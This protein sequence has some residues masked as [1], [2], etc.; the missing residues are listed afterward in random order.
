MDTLMLLMTKF[1]TQTPY[2]YYELA[3]FSLVVE[4]R[5][6]TAAARLAGYPQSA[7]TLQIQG[8]EKA[9]GVHL[10]KRTTRSISLTGAGEYLFR[11]ASRLVGDVES[12]LRFLQ[13]EFANA[14]KEIRVAVS[15]SIGLAYL[16]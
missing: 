9:L 3:L 14:P 4:H 15:H 10:L 2:D 16:P 13:Q 7:V 12:S 11:E 5:S 8:I 6:F 1:L